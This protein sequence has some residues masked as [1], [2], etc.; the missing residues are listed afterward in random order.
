[1]QVASFVIY[2][3]HLYSDEEIGRALKTVFW[4][5]PWRSPSALK[6]PNQFNVHMHKIVDRDGH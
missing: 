6:F 5:T 4:A 3:A 1:M 2:M